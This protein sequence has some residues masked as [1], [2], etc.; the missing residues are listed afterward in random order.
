MRSG[1]LGEFFVF[2]VVRVNEFQRGRET[3]SCGC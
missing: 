2:E 3:G 1:S